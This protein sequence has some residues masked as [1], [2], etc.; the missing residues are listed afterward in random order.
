MVAC[1]DILFVEIKLAHYS[2]NRQAFITKLS[3]MAL[4]Y[5]STIVVTMF[6]YTGLKSLII[7]FLRLVSTWSSPDN[8][9][10]ALPS[11]TST[12]SQSRIRVLTQFTASKSRAA[13]YECLVNI[14]QYLIP[15]GVSPGGGESLITKRALRHG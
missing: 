14:V 13:F 3:T 4:C 12:L 7:T 6:A 9:L 2:T 10:P 8:H 11:Q 5:S 15:F 1:V